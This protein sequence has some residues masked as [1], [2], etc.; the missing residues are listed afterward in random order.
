MSNIVISLT[1]PFYVSIKAL[2]RILKDFKR[3][4]TGFMHLNAW[5]IDVIVSYSSCMFI[6]FWNNSCSLCFCIGTF[7]G[8]E[9][10]I[11]STPCC[12]C[13]LKVS[14][15]SLVY[16]NI[17]YCWKISLFKARVR[18]ASYMGFLGINPV[19]FLVLSGCDLCCCTKWFST[20]MTIINK[21]DFIEQRDS[22]CCQGD[23]F[24]M[25]VSLKIGCKW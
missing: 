11:Q 2:V 17:V 25:V 16:C 4:F 6:L 19:I 18:T 9:E 12:S 20:L 23:N 3:R 1:F 21:H 14:H 13:G 15:Q 7:H 10:S 8:H 22:I 5:Q 24:V